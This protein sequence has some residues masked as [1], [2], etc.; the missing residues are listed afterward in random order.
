MEEHRALLMPEGA[1]MILRS[2]GLTAWHQ[3]RCLG[4]AGICQIWPGR[5]EAWAL[6]GADVGQFM[7][8][9]VRHVRFVLDSYQCRRIEISVKQGNAEGHRIAKLLGF[10]EP[11]GVLRAFHP[12]GSDMCMYARIRVLWP[13]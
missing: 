5:A 9:L 2:M 11:E 1:D 10:G 12:D 7:K 3:S 8:P 13:R 4:M 6:F